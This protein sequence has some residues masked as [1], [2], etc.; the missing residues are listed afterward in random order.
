MSIKYQSNDIYSKNQM[1]LSPLNR[2]TKFFSEEEYQYHLDLAREHLASI[3]SKVIF[4]KVDKVESQTDDLY[5]NGYTEQQTVLPPIEIPAIV[6]FETP[7]NKSYIEDKGVL[8]YEEYG[9]LIVSMLLSDLEQLKAEIT[10]GD[11]IGYRIDET[12]IVYFEVSNDAQKHFE[13]NKMMF[14]YKPFWKTIV[15]TPTQINLD[16]L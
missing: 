12:T 6:K 7:E 13:N 9:N 1:N 11:Y 15:C 3:D 14:G 4:L 10:Y 16:L 5:G 8:R 2:N